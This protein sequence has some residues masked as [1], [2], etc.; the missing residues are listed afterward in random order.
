MS[1]FIP[2]GIATL[3]VVSLA[4]C[5][6]DSISPDNGMTVPSTVSLSAN[7]RGPE[8]VVGGEVVVKLK[9][10]ANAEAVARDHGLSAGERGY[11]DAFVVMRGGLGAEH[12]NANALKS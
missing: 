4:A 12:A 5:S 10:V 3:A 1:R 9:N 11:K 2:V 8:Q 7:A 6:N